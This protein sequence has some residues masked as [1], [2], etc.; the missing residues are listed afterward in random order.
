[1]ERSKALSALQALGHDTRLD[2]LRLLVSAGDD[3]VAA[4]SLAL[5]LKSGAS[6]LSFHLAQLEQAGLIRS[7]RVSRNIYYAIDAAGLGQTIAY[8]L[9]DCCGDHPGVLACCQHVGRTAVTPT[10]QHPVEA[11]EDITLF[12]P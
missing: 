9:N 8:L 5:S 11:G 7:R 3:G 12:H 10:V 4:G 2:L 1:M 6:R